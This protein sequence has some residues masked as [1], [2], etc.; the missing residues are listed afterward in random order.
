MHESESAESQGRGPRD[1]SQSHFV[2]VS[3]GLASGPG[4]HGIWMA[5]GPP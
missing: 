1:S 2:V 3:V 5:R 4:W